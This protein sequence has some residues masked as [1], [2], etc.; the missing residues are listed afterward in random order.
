[1]RISRRF[2][3]LCTVSLQAAVEAEFNAT[4]GKVFYDG[5]NMIESDWLLFWRFF[6]N[7]DFR[8]AFII[9]KY[10]GWEESPKQM[11]TDIQS[12]NPLQFAKLSS[13]KQFYSIVLVSRSEVELEKFLKM[14]RA[15]SVKMDIESFSLV[16]NRVGKDL[17]LKRVLHS[18]IQSHS[19]NLSNFA[20]F[21]GVWFLETNEYVLKNTF[22]KYRS[23]LPES[24]PQMGVLFERAYD[25]L[26]DLSI[27]KMIESLDDLNS[28][29]ELKL[30]ALLKSQSTVMVKPT[31][32]FSKEFIRLH[33]EEGVW[34]NG[35]TVVLG[36]SIGGALAYGLMK[37]MEKRRK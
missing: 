16:S 35:M 26:Q 8:R 19:Y 10:I 30:S 9:A 31:L 22:E 24:L 33:Q 18:E 3:N 17:I 28:I 6:V 12:E 11:V 13:K 14:L 7:F 1:M 25:R 37:W 4:F 29:D 32:G 15:N 36:L 2:L 34:N 27:P 23:L 20:S 5:V 21:D